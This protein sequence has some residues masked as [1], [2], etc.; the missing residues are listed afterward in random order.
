E[1]SQR[2]F[3]RKHGLDNSAE[4]TTLRWIQS[5]EVL[6]AREHAIGQAMILIELGKHL[7]HCLA[8]SFVVRY[9]R[10][11]WRRFDGLAVIDAVSRKC[12]VF[13]AAAFVEIDELWSDPRSI[14]EVG[15][16]RLPIVAL[17]VE[18]TNE[19]EQARIAG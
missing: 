19:I 2:L 8:V 12:D 10:P 5:G 16:I 13:Q 9:D 4:F 15:K 14:F 7:V 6:V 11:D 1:N 17:L 18:Q 3:K